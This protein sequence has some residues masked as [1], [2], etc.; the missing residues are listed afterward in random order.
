MF[1]KTPSRVTLVG[2]TTDIAIFKQRSSGETWPE[3]APP[4][5][6][7]VWEIEML[8]PAVEIH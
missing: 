6:G 1:F 4:A 5:L 3:A 2:S 7:P 8:Q